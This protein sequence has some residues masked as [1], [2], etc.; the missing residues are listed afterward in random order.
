[1]MTGDFVIFKGELKDNTGKVVIPA[2]TDLQAD[3]PRAREMDYLVEGVVGIDR[4][5]LV[6]ALARDAKELR[7]AARAARHAAASQLGGAAGAM[8]LFAFF[9]LLVGR[10]PARRCIADMCSGAFGSWFSTAELAVPR[11]AVDADR[12]VHGAAGAARAG[13]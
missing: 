12:V 11:R 4:S 13:R 1:M 9:L 5:R 2:G 8:L 7:A 3:R 10:Q 6:K